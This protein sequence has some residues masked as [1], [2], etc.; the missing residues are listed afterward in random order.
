MR[1]ANEHV[2]FINYLHYCDLSYVRNELHLYAFALNNKFAL[3]AVE[4]NGAHV[5]IRMIYRNIVYWFFVFLSLLYVS[6]HR[7][8][9]LRTNEA[10]LL[11]AFIKTHLIYNQRLLIQ[12]IIFAWRDRLLRGRFTHSRN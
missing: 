3:I 5:T 12:I 4:I 10:H 8:P 7:L 11:L 2:V 9:F 6:G 1:H